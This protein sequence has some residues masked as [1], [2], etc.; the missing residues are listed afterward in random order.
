M[1][2]HTKYLNSRWL[3]DNTFVQLSQLK[4]KSLTLWCLGLCLVG[5]TQSAVL[6]GG[7]HHGQDRVLHGK[8]LSEKAHHLNDDGKWPTLSL[9]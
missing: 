3:N 7:E 1:Y 2:Q 5:L 4:M 9:S 8:K 6:G